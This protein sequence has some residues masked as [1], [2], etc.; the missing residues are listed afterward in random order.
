MIFFKEYFEIGNP[1]PIAVEF[2]CACGLTNF[3]QNLV[4][5]EP[6]IVSCRGCE[7]KYKLIF[8]LGEEQRETK[9]LGLE[10]PIV[11]TWKRYKLDR[12]EKV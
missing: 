5:D 12:I 11:K 2:K 8:K 7:Q 4:F 1:N 10:E 6:M 3:V 9:V